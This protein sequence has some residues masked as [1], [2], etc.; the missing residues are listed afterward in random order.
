MHDFRNFEEDYNT[1]IKYLENHEEEIYK[2]NKR[3]GTI[4]KNDN[5]M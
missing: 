3:Y 2:I 5:K 1:N 4:F